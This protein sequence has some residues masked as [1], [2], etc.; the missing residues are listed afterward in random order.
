MF[1]YLQAE[2]ADGETRETEWQTV[3]LVDSG[4]APEAIPAASTVAQQ[5]QQ[6]AVPVRRG[7]VDQP[8][9]RGKGEEQ[10]HHAKIPDA[11]VFVNGI[12]IGQFF[13]HGFPSPQD[14]QAV[15]GM[16]LAM[17]AMRLMGSA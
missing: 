2:N 13:F 12:H 8:H 15:M 14:S 1:Y 10:H 17:P 6:Q 3:K 9:R 16:A 5:A 11:A 4:V 7:A